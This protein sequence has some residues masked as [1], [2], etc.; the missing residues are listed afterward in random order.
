MP[1]FVPNFIKKHR[2]KKAY[3]VQEKIMNANNINLIGTHSQVIIDYFDDELGYFVGRTSQNAPDVDYYIFFD[4]SP[5][6][7]VG[8]IYQ[9]RLENYLSGIFKGDI[10]QRAI[11][12][13][14]ICK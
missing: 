12:I 9:A 10:L 4:N 1:N 11:Q 3:K 6:I 7:K 5:S 2:L 14:R 8:E 13:L